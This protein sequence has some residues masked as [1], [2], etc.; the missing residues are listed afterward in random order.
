MSSITST[1]GV[2]DPRAMQELF[3]ERTNLGTTQI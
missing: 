3:L 2:N 1:S